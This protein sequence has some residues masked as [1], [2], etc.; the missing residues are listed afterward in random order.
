[1]E[2]GK[3]CCLSRNKKSG[4]CWAGGGGTAVLQQVK[5]LPIRQKEGKVSG[6]TSDRQ[7]VGGDTGGGVKWLF[8]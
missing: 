7:M 3:R 5:Q 4:S 2:D 1:M 6:N 8:S